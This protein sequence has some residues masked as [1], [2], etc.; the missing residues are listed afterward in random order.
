M[1]FKRIERLL[2]G[3]VGFLSELLL[4]RSC[5]PSDISPSSTLI[6]KKDRNKQKGYNLIRE[7]DILVDQILLLHD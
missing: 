7:N 6:Q 2:P 1:K 3:L 5:P 4:P